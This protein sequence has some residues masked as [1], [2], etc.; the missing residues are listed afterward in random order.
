MLVWAHRAAKVQE[1]AWLV[2]YHP[3]IVAGGHDTD[4]TRAQF[5]LR[6]VGHHPVG[7]TREDIDEMVDLAQVGAG[8][9]LDVFGPAPADM[10]GDARAGAVAEADGLDGS[11][12]GVRR[13]SGAVKL[14]LSGRAM[15]CS[16]F[17]CRFS[18][19]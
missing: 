3:A 14:F 19:R 12:G 8:D 6:S 18:K 1:D 15:Q 9:W 13:S 10:V 11:V 7:A 16:C 4:I 17:Y 2:I 5:E